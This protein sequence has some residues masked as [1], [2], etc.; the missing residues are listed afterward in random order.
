MN[1]DSNQ[2]PN[3]NLKLVFVHLG[4]NRVD[5]LWSNLK[6]LLVR[7]PNLDINLVSDQYHKS[8]FDMTKINFHFYEQPEEVKVALE[9]LKHDTKFRAGFWLLTLERFFALNQFHQLYPDAKVLH[10]ESDILLFP[11]FPFEEFSKLEKLAWLRVDSKRDV[12]A[13]LY[14]PNYEQTNWFAKQILDLMSLDRHTTDM[15]GLHDLRN[16]FNQNIQVLPS[17]S[18]EIEESPSGRKFPVMEPLKS[19]S[20]LET[21]FGGIFDPAAYGMWL[22]GSDP[23]NYYGK[24]ISFDTEEILRGG[25]FFNPGI[26]SYN[27]S[28]DEGLTIS[29]GKKRVRVWNLHVHSKDTRLLGE[30]WE[31]RLSLVVNASKRGEILSE[32][33]IKSLY[34]LFINNLRNRTFLSW[35]MH[36]KSLQPFVMKLRALRT[37]FRRIN[38]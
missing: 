31:S 19:L 18:S 33:H 32:F 10:I 25:T 30:N 20:A 3:K 23:R 37:R 1:E 12:A 29:L 28:K 17:M 14:S 22:T 38:K 8:K 26:Y 4:E 35:L 21:R 36:I 9:N 11:G 24:Q 5:H 7:F 6:A 13:I 27:F 34:W 2:V 15:I 16:K